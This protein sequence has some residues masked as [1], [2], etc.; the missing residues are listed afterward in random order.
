MNIDITRL[1]QRD[2]LLDQAIGLAFGVAVA[3]ALVVASEVAGA[4]DDE[5]LSGAFWLTVVST[6]IRS[7]FS[8]VATIAGLRIPGISGGAA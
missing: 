3:V 2:R 1:I 8:A 6:A 4:T 5:L 7:A